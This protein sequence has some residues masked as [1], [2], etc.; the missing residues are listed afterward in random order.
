LHAFEGYLLHGALLS[1]L[2]ALVIRR[3]PGFGYLDDAEG[4]F[5]IRDWVEI[6]TDGRGL[7]ITVKAD[8]LPS[9]RPLINRNVQSD[10]LHYIPSTLRT[11]SIDSIE[12]APSAIGPRCRMDQTRQGAGC[13]ADRQWHKAGPV[14]RGTIT[15]GNAKIRSIVLAR[16][17]PLKGQRWTRNS[18][19]T[20]R[21]ASM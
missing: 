5:S 4:G 15:S 12:T 10:E 8:E 19:F 21:C 9:L 18:W 17:R 14:I 13:L 7:F 11:G 1:G 3:H 2:F 16:I 6:D 20:I